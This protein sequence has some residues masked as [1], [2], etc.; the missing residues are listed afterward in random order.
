MINVAKFLQ[1]PIAFRQIKKKSPRIAKWT[2]YEST[3]RYF[4]FG[5]YIPY[6]ISEPSFGEH[7][8]SQPNMSAKCLGQLPPEYSKSRHRFTAFMLSEFESRSILSPAVPQLQITELLYRKRKVVDL[9][10]Q[11]HKLQNPYLVSL[12]LSIVSTC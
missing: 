4:Q 12:T 1:N 10:L 2:S 9:S 3:Q 11:K 6:L 5:I 7:F 8:F